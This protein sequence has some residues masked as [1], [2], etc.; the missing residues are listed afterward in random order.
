M[1]LFVSLLCIIAGVWLLLQFA[2]QTYLSVLIEDVDHA[3]GYLKISV[4][5]QN[6][7]RA[8]IGKHTVLLQGLAY[9]ADKGLR[10]PESVPFRTSSVRSGEEPLEWHEPREIFKDLAYLFPGETVT[11]EC[12]VPLPAKAALVHVGVQFNASQGPVE[13]LIS[14]FFTL[15]HCWESAAIHLV[16]ASD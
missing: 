16:D 13:A 1:A 10:L 3:H 8:R 15:N 9:G 14:R 6:T 5:L 11:S 12:L 7:S 4:T 2:P